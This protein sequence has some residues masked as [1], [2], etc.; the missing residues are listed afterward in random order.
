MYGD[1]NGN[2]MV[3]N[4]GDDEEDDDENVVN[5]LFGLIFEMDSAITAASTSM[6]AIAIA[7]SLQWVA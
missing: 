4:K 6:V 1:W 2:S 7:L 5:M 3:H